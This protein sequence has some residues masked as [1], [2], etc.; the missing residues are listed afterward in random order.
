MNGIFEAAG[1]VCAFMTSRG[2]EYCVI[3]GLAVQRWGEPRT[4]LDA[5]F[6]LLADWGDEARYAAAL[7]ERFEARISDAHAFAVERRVV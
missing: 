7:L 3:G 5:D 6:T 2:W 4:T 1:E